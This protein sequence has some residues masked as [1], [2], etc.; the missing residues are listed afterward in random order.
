MPT[1]RPRPHALVNAVLGLVPWALLPLGA[2]AGGGGPTPE[3]PA[4]EEPPAVEQV[5][6]GVYA[7]EPCADLY[8]PELIPIFKLHITPTN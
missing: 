8:D 4:E 2:C 7:A 6:G 1:R 5:P 3:T